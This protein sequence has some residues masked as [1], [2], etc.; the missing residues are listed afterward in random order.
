MAV[1]IRLVPYVNYIQRRLF[2]GVRLEHAAD[3]QDVLCP[4]ESIRARPAIV[5]P[6]QIDAI[7]GTA[8]G[9]TVALELDAAVA[10]RLKASPTIAYRIADAILV[11]GSVY[12]GSFKAFIA[13][14]SHFRSREVRHVDRAGL[15]S[16]HLAGRYFGHWLADDS[17]QYELAQERGEPLCFPLPIYSEHRDFYAAQL[18]QTY[19]PTS[20]A[21]VRDLTLYQDF[22]WG[23]HQNSL[24]RSLTRALRQRA[25]NGQLGKR[26]HL[27]YLKRGRTGMR[28]VIQNED[29][30]VA[31][32]AQNGFITIDLETMSLAQ[33]HAALSR[34]KIVVSIEGS[35]V[36]HGIFSMPEDSGLLL[37][38]PPD[39]FLAFHRGWTEAAGIWFGFVVGKQ[40]DDGYLFAPSDIMRTLDLMLGRIEARAL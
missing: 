2:G 12:R 37:L 3:R 29:E 27:I 21:V 26:E 25:R 38:Q 28:R 31:R 34:A 17:L 32:L 22:Y 30:L 5:L 9:T 11:D 40:A 33:I 23:I 4:E 7:I 1:P 39:R 18:R 6:G 19:S 35:H 16:S 10:E 13:A 36:S 15:A 8:D 20:R 14:R 24:R